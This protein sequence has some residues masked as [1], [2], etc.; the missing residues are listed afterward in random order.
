MWV[1]SSFNTH[2]TTEITHN[3]EHIY[4]FKTVGFNFNPVYGCS[5]V[6]VSYKL[7]GGS[8]VPCPTQPTCREDYVDLQAILLQSVGN[9]TGR[10]LNLSLGL[11][12]F[13]SLFF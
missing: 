13:S 1:L 11:C 9:N 2:H 6:S 7:Q 10:G 3:L 12:K 4:V 8:Y 5:H